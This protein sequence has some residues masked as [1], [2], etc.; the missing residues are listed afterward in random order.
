MVETPAPVSP[1]RAR[2][3]RSFL[4]GSNCG[5]ERPV[6]HAPVSL[7]YEVQPEKPPPY[8]PSPV[9]VSH[10]RPE[11]APVSPAASV[12][13]VQ[14]SHVQPAPTNSQP[15]TNA[16]PNSQKPDQTIRS[17][18][19]PRSNNSSNSPHTA[20][21]STNSPPHTAQPKPNSTVRL[22]PFERIG[23]VGRQR[24][25]EVRKDEINS[26]R[27]VV[28]W[29]H[30]EGRAYPHLSRD[31]KRWYE[32]FYFTTPM[33]GEKPYNAN[34]TYEQHVE[35]YERGQAWIRRHKLTAPTRP[36]GH[37][38]PLDLQARRAAD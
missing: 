13:E 16:K 8:S 36:L 25:Y 23:K 3:P 15:P 29:R 11:P 32:F 35:A 30:V 34:T 28:L 20:Q 4:P 6:D 1:P 38:A 9:P 31:M 33:K 26:V 14:P 17:I 2:T 19:D 21:G 12:D 37:S 27:D 18:R 10:I 22:E 5:L 24:R 7:V